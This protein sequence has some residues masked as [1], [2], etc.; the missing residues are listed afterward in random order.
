[1]VV[2]EIVSQSACIF[3][4]ISSS[5]LDRLAILLVKMS[6]KFQI[7]SRSGDCG[8]QFSKFLAPVSAKKLNYLCCVHGMNQPQRFDNFFCRLPPGL[9]NAPYFMNCSIWS[10]LGHILLQLH[11]FRLN[12]V[13]FCGKRSQ[14]NQKVNIW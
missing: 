11:I 1:M 12:G 2:A 14:A 7:I 4:Q 10:I 3:A 5:F 6:H 13:D 9:P 8:G